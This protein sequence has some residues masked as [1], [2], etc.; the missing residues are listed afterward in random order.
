MFRAVHCLGLSLNWLTDL[1]AKFLL[2]TGVHCRAA[3]RGGG[4]SSKNKGKLELS[5]ICLKGILHQNLIPLSPV[6]FSALTFYVAQ[7]MPL[8]QIFD[9]FKLIAVLSNF[10]QQKKYQNII[11]SVFLSNIWL[12]LPQF[13]H[14]LPF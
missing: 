7:R 9:I 12:S 14:A 13:K 5:D 3:R 1:H 6:S 2:Y 4:S 8:A 11:I 10:L